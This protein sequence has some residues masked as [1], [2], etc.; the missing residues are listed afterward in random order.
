MSAAEATARPAAAPPFCFGC[1]GPH[2][3]QADA[4]GQPAGAGLVVAAALFASVLPY[5]AYRQNILHRN[6][7]PSP[8]HWLGTD[9]VGRDVAARLA[10]G[11]RVSLIVAL[12]SSL[13]A[14]AIGVLIGMVAGYLGG[15][16][17][18]LVMRFVDSMYA[19]PETLFAILIASLVKGQLSGHSSGLLEPLAEAY[20]MSGGLLGVLLTLGLTCWLTTSRLVR[21]QVLTLK[22]AE[23]VL[24][25]RLAGASGWF[26]V[27]T[28]LLPNVAAGHPR[29][30]DLRGAQRHPARGGLELHRRRGRSA[31]AEL[32]HDDRARRP[33]DPV[34]SPS[35]HRAGRWRSARPC[36][37][38]MWSGTR[39]ATWSIR[40]C[41]AGAAGLS[42]GASAGAQLLLEARELGVWFPARRGFRRPPRLGARRR[43][44]QPQRRCRAKPWRSS[45]RAVA[46]RRR[47][48]ARS[49]CS[50]PDRGTVEFAGVELPAPA[51]GRCARRGA[52][53]R[54]S[55]RIPMPASIRARRS[56]RSSASRCS[57][58]A[59]RRDAAAARR[60]LLDL[61]GL[62]AESA[63]ACRAS[64][65]AA[66]ASASASPGR[67]RRSPAD[68]LRR[69]AL[70]A[71]RL[72]PGPDRQ[73]AAAAAEPARADLRLH[74]A[75]SAVVRQMATASP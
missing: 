5:D 49:S 72:D 29:R 42:D 38:S 57:S 15:L 19:F 53:S 22:N 61:V 20:R 74:L 37:R 7:P 50:A 14:L 64:S 46:A 73:P 75:R 47:W 27:R 39:C 41:A 34:L 23:Y 65:A 55:S 31:D 71:R 44:H 16:T 21:S 28:H 43:R 66:S 40:R 3:A 6:E 32:G 48:A 54:S 62:G 10:V 35:A 60:E 45:A 52:S 24:A 63:H 13:I 69:A 12:T 11:A 1:G 4:R 9:E 8:L 68:R 2:A 59:S 36:W 67:W 51:A 58:R 30:G 70:R 17:D 56:R 26:I 25:A 33:V 18:S